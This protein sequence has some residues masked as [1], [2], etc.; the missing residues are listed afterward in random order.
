MAQQR[1]RFYNQD[2]QT[3]FAKKHSLLDKQYMSDFDA[4]STQ[5]TS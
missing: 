5:T 1:K 2:E 4:M 3:H